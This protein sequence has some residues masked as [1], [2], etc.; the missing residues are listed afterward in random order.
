M[1]APAC[2]WCQPGRCELA[3]HGF[4]PRVQPRG[5][6][7]RRYICRAEGRTVSLAGLFRGA[8]WRSRSSGKGRDA[9]GGGGA[10]AAPRG[11]AS[12]QPGCSG[13]AVKHEALHDRR[14]W[15]DWQQFSRR[16]C[17]RCGRWRR[18]SWGSWRPRWA[19]ARAVGGENR[20]PAK[21]QV[22]AARRLA[23]GRQK[24][25]RSA[26]HAAAAM[27]EAADREHKK[28]PPAGGRLAGQIVVRSDS[29]QPRRLAPEVVD[30]DLVEREKRRTARNPRAILSRRWSGRPVPAAPARS[31]SA[32][33]RADDAT[34]VVPHAVRNVSR[35]GLA[36][37]RQ[38]D[39]RPG[40]PCLSCVV[41]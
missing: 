36:H 26:R 13:G 15:R 9:G 17:G 34:R 16:C 14:P 35:S 19:S 30:A 6:W 4:Y 37:G 5:A 27:Q 25:P 22:A 2:P 10:A 11:P 7:V 31:R 29:R 33:V 32:P 39:P 28:P 12:A 3:P 24:T 18:R 8:P 40:L 41:G 20:S 23:W 21:K 38:S 1:Q